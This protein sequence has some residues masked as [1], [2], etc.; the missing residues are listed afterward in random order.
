MLR[1]L[2]SNQPKL[3]CSVPN[4]EIS[5]LQLSDNVQWATWAICCIWKLVW[6]LQQWSSSS[7]L[8]SWWTESQWLVTLLML[9]AAS[10]TPRPCRHHPPASGAGKMD[11]CRAYI[12]ADY[13]QFDYRPFSTL[14]LVARNNPCYRYHVNRCGGSKPYHVIHVS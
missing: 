12:L 3:Y 13:P 5:T 8:T 10:S 4:H 11:Y 7:C 6:C 14:P 9:S 2:K 1:K